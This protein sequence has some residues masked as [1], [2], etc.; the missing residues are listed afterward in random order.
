MSEK[1]A[2]WS[3]SL[4]AQGTIDTTQSYVFVASLF[5]WIALQ[6]NVLLLESGTSRQLWRKALLMGVSL[7]ALEYVATIAFTEIRMV[8]VV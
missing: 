4:D 3:S 7:I 2:S 8:L 1:L 5:T 6:N